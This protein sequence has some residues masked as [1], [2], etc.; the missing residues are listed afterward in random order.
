MNILAQFMYNSRKLQYNVVNNS[1]DLNYRKYKWLLTKISITWS[2][3][4]DY[5]WKSAKLRLRTIGPS[6]CIRI[7]LKDDL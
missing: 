2:F 5:N 7:D 6:D 3:M 4:T 1:L